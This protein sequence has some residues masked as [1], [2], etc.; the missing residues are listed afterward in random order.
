MGLA[1]PLAYGDDLFLHGAPAPPM[2]AFAALMALAAPLGLHCHPAKCAVHSADHA[3]ATAIAHQLGE[4]HAPKGLLAAGT[5]VGTP[6]FQTTN[7]KIC[8]TQAYHQMDE[9]LARLLGAQDQRLVLHGSLKK[10]VAH[11][12]QGC[13]WEQARQWG[14][15]RAKW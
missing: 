8:A 10:C 5:P 15:L 2:R 7:A 14:A 3:A 6:T 4:R 12:P 1:R 13:S 9:H 11:L